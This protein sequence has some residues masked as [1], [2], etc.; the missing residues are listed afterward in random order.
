[1]TTYLTY[2]QILDKVKKDLD[3]EDELFV[4]QTEMLGYANEAVRDA[5]AEILTIYED[6]FLARATIT[7]VSGTEAHSLPSNI[8]AH[9]IRGLVYKNGATVY[10]LERM[11]DWRK[12]SEYSENIAT[13]SGNVYAWFLDNTAV[14]APKILLSPTPTESGAFITAWYIRTANRFLD[15]GLATDICDIPEFVSYVIQYMKTRCYEKEVGHP[16]I[17]LAQAELERCRA[18]MVETL[19]AMVPDAQNELEPDFSFYGEMT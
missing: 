5:E 17:P 1:M 12:F 15:N 14:G 13:G 18:K 16:N 9:K 11:R 3:L 10:Q 6:Y 19:T 8:Y 2:A 7:L 4:Q